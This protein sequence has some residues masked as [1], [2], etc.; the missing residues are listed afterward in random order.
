MTD[1]SWIETLRALPRDRPLFMAGG[2]GEPLAVIDAVR[3][4]PDLFA[5][6]VLYSGAIPRVNLTD[7]TGGAAGA[8]LRVLFPHAG[9]AAEAQSLLPLPYSRYYEW[10][11]TRGGIGLAF[12]QVARCR[13]GALSLGLSADFTPALI[14]AGVPLIGQINPALPAAP[15][16]PRVPA[17]RFAALFEAETPLPVYDD[18]VPDAVT[19]AIGARVATLIRPGDTVQLGLGK[20]QAAI[21][22]ALAADPRQLALHGGMFSGAALALY[23]AGH[24]SAAT[25]GVIL[26]SQGLYDRAPD[27]DR[28]ALRPV[29]ETHGAAALAVHAA[30]VSANAILSID[31]AGQATGESIAGRTVSAPGGLPDFHR[32]ALRAPEGRAILALRS[33]TPKGEST[34]VPRHPAGTR[35]SLGALDAD[36]VVTEHGIAE[37]RHRDALDRAQALIDIAAP[38]HKEALAEAWTA[39]QVTS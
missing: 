23:D 31:L 11:S 2:C 16:A 32:A 3:E 29:R 12:C 35:I 20:V 33:Q 26:G 1:R 19:A 34:I 27:L 37:L 38:D 14:E 8:R 7:P 28:L 39:T 5:G 36:I 24:V 21:L 13:D 4:S 25:A 22:D 15:S 10:L 9:T 6:R 30:L 17:E 18:G